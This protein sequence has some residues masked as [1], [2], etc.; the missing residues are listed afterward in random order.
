MKATANVFGTILSAVLSVVLVLLL[1]CSPVV[2]ALCSFTQPET[3]SKV[4]KDIDFVEL[5]TRH[6]ELRTTLEKYGIDGHFLDG[7]TE[8]ELMEQLVEAYIQS[9]FE[10]KAFDPHVAE[11]I[12]LAHKAE[13]VS[14]F[15]RLAEERGDNT[16]G[17]SDE[18]FFNMILD[19]IHTEWDKITA[20][21]PS[22]EDMGLTQKDYDEWETVHGDAVQ[23]LNAPFKLNQS[24]ISPEEP[25]EKEIPLGKLVMYLRD[26]VPVIA[27]SIVAAVISALILLFRWPRF[28]GF[29]WLAVIYLL[30]AVLLFAGTGA[31]SFS[32]AQQMLPSEGVLDLLLMPVLSVFTA[33]MNRCGV[34]F[35][36]IGVLC[37]AVFILG[38][39]LLRNCKNR[40][41]AQAEEHVPQE[42][43]QIQSAETIENE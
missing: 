35:A 23:P 21:L 32:G 24:A 30:D 13:T 42:V 16:A 4:I 41:D 37:I 14:L 1:L 10:G 7:I 34:I 36:V 17:I 40:R 38:R 2:S 5:V 22:A 18:E 3:I 39:I 43:P 33:E 6:E 29:M 26:G 25:T 9:I 27:V 8:T 31:L 12:I 15:R 11:D 28:K 20:A 19:A